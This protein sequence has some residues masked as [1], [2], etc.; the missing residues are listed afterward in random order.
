MHPAIRGYIDLIRNKFDLTEINIIGINIYSNDLKPLLKELQKTENKDVAK[1]INIFRIVLTKLTHIELPDTL[2][3][4][5]E[6][7]LY[8]N[9]LQQVYIPPSLTK[10]KIIFLHNNKLEYFNIPKSLKNICFLEISN[11]YLTHIT[12][13]NIRQFALDNIDQVVLLG[14]DQFTPDK[15]E[16]YDLYIHFKVIASHMKKS[17]KKQQDLKN[18]AA[19]M[20]PIELASILMEFL[21]INYNQ[22]GYEITKLKNSFFEQEKIITD[23]EKSDSFTKIK[24]DYREHFLLAQNKARLDAFNMKKLL[25]KHKDDKEHLYDIKSKKIRLTKE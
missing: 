16:A 20:L 4:L 5:T 19:R 3:E 18:M 24:D 21:D 6:L 9:L 22:I 2:T 15:I 8:R 17:L 13:V 10:L 1:K 23:F 7:H 25:N 11:N 12:K 14:L